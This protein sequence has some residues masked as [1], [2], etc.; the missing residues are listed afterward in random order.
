MVEHID[1]TCGGP[2][3]GWMQ[4]AYTPADA[5]RIIGENKLAI[6]LGVEVDSLGNWRRLEDL[7]QASQ[8]DREQARRLIAAELDWLHSLGVRQIT[9]IHLT[10]NAFGGTAIYMRF[11][12][13]LNVIVTGRHYETEDGWKSG[14][15]YR[16][17]YDGGLVGGVQ[18]KVAGSGP[19]LS[20]SPAMNRRSLMYD[21]RG[22]KALEKSTTP[23]PPGRS[24][25][26]VLGLTIYGVI[27]LEEMRARGMI[28]DVDH[29]SQKSLDAA[30][31][32]ME[33]ADYPV[34]SSHSWFRDLAFTGD[35]EFDPDRPERY[36]TGDVHKVAKT[37][38]RWTSRPSTAASSSSASRGGSTTSRAGC[39]HSM[40][41][42]AR[43]RA[44]AS[45]IGRPSSARPT[46]WVAA[47]PRTRT[48][49]TR[50]PSGAGRSSRSGTSGARWRA[51]IPRWRAAR[52]GPGATSTSTSTGWRTT[53]CCPTCCRTC[54][55]P[56]WRSRIS[57]PSSGAPR[58][59]SGCGRSVN[60]G[61]ES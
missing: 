57:R 10:D 27:L 16:L 39:G 17:E 52:P 18:R 48:S 30:L 2:G 14:I 61:P 38:P 35:G 36:P 51:T 13:V 25:A 59:T 29:M 55:T 44:P 60:S 11:L 56:G 24:H 47:P 8:S 58:I 5:R 23:T 46:W 54:A 32:L 43:S 34:I 12:E 42:S 4:I 26:N 53:G 9:P 40:K 31:D 28:I 7:D 50:W 21:M 22:V 1:E 41:L 3:R 45:M 37:C 6:V 49:P 33:P 19:K 20:P 15:R